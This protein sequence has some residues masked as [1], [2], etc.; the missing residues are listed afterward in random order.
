[1]GFPLDSTTLRILFNIGVYLRVGVLLFGD[2]KYLLHTECGH[3]SRLCD[4]QYTAL[5]QSFCST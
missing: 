1:M 5:R 3:N 2:C 4:T